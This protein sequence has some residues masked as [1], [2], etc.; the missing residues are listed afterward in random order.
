MGHDDLK[1]IKG[2]NHNFTVYFLFKYFCF[3]KIFVLINGQGSE[4]L[5]SNNAF[6]F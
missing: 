2:E 4:F 1:N 6:D 5:L 3:F